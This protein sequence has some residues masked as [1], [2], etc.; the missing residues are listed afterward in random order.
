LGL[1]AF[2]CVQY[3]CVARQELVFF[4]MGQKKF[5]MIKIKEKEG[6]NKKKENRV[7]S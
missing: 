4:I 1:F 7:G 6:D 2:V 3:V 5:K